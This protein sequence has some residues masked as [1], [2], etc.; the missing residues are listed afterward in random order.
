MLYCINLLLIYLKA[1]YKIGTLEWIC[2]TIYYWDII[3]PL[4][5]SNSLSVSIIVVLFPAI[6]KIVWFNISALLLF[7]VVGLMLLSS[8]IC[9]SPNFH[10]V[11][12][13][14]SNTLPISSMKTISKQCVSYSYR[15]NILIRQ[16][17]K[18]K[19]FNEYFTVLIGW[20]AILSQF[21][22]IYTEL[23]ECIYGW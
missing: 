12:S 21:C 4:L 22:P 3:Y 5:S 1:F 13:S 9:A 11:S 18:S 23:A 20:I 14:I 2:V 7:P 10:I 15:Y 6:D 16:L 17:Y 19:I 8:F